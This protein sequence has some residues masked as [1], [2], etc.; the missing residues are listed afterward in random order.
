[1]TEKTGLVPGKTRLLLAAARLSQR[2]QLLPRSPSRLDGVIPDAGHFWFAS[3]D[4]PEQESWR[5]G[6]W[7]D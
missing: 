4:V 1:M 3:R 2:R 5:H 7:G 6:P